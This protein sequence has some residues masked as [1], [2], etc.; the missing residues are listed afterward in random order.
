MNLRSLLALFA[1]LLTTG[2]LFLDDVPRACDAVPSCPAEHVEVSMCGVGATCVVRQ[3]CGEEILC[4]QLVDQCTAYPSCGPGSYEVPVCDDPA[5]C[6]AVALCGQTIWCQREEVCD[7]LPACEVHE[8]QVDGCHDGDPFCHDVEVC[9]A[10]I[11]CTEV[12]A[13]EE[14]APTCDL[15]DIWTGRACPENVSGCYEVRSSCDPSIVNGHCIPA[16]EPELCEAFPVC[17]PGYEEVFECSGPGC[18]AV[19]VCGHSILCE[20]D[21]AL[22]EAA[23]TCPPD[24][25]PKDMCRPGHSCVELQACGRKVQC[26][27]ERDSECLAVPTCPPGAVEVEKC[28][29]PM[30][31]CEVVTV[32]G[33][34]ILCQA[35]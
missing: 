4:E 27:G 17:E 2:C 12:S 18:R 11:Q 20:Q 3:A 23:L 30:G 10:V 29:L 26:E 25:R 9:G 32:C 24:T 28:E 14:P 6:E 22:C 15:D 7:A 13:C 21:E 35:G 33:H 5:T 34:S 8:V 19:S 1:P 31:R 16:P